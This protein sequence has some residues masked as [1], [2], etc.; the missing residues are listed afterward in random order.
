[1]A[2]I[3]IRSMARVVRIVDIQI[4]ISPFERI[5]TIDNTDAKMDTI[6]KIVMM[7]ITVSPVSYTH[8]DVY[9]RQSFN[10]RLYE[11]LL[12]RHRNGLLIELAF[13][14]SDFSEEEMGS[15]T[16]MVREARERVSSR[17]EVVRC[18]DVIR[19]EHQLLALEQPERL[20]EED[21]RKLLEAMRDKKS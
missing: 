10:R 1:M 9:K 12:E 20:S 17:E 18:A 15:I 11:R 14:A 5:C 21:I 3:V 7:L 6:P 13:L 16:R 2:I 8:L 19:K 4:Q